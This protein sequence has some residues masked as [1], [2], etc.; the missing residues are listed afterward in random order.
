M[1]TELLDLHKNNILNYLFDKNKTIKNFKE[2]KVITL[3]NKWDS[4]LN[5]PHELYILR[6]TKTNKSVI[7]SCIIT[8]LL[9][10]KDRIIHPILLIIFH[11]ELLDYIEYYEMNEEFDIQIVSKNKKILKDIKPQ[12]NFTFKLYWKLINDIK[13][14]QFL[15]FYDEN[16]LVKEIINSLYY[17]ITVEEL[18]TLNQTYIETKKVRF[19]DLCLNLDID[20]KLFEELSPIKYVNFTKEKE[21]LN[22]SQSNYQNK[23]LIEINEL[24]FY[25]KQQYIKQL[26]K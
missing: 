1:T 15:N 17:T 24:I 12:I 16:Q 5:Y 11:T 7:V 18:I 4:L 22:D 21:K 14:Q 8:S 3:T 2:N 6:R 10:K 13:I 23:I 25:E 19:N 20:D 9:E 26:E